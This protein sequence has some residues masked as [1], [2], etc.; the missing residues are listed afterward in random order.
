MGISSLVSCI[1]EIF[2]FG[3]IPTNTRRSA[4]VS[5]IL[6]KCYKNRQIAIIIT[7]LLR[8]CAGG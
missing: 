6:C 5:L 1:D 3:R 2:Y 4:N 8:K 7:S